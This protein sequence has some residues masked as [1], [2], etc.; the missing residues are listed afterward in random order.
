M[1]LK[2]IHTDKNPSYMLTKIVLKDKLELC[3]RLVGMDIKWWLEDRCASLR[4]LEG[5]LL[6]LGPW[7]V[8]PKFG[9]K[10]SLSLERRDGEKVRREKEKRKKSVALC[11]T[12]MKAKRKKERSRRREIEGGEEE[13]NEE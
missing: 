8:Q 9:K 7:W 1:K 2:K 6:V 4:G 10:K 3:R 5:R 13:E 12:K 11:S